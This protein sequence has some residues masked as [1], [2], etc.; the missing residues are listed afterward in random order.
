MRTLPE[1]FLLFGLYGL[2]Y[3]MVEGTQ[4]AFAS[5]LLGEKFRAT[6]L[7]TFHTVIALVTLPSSVIAGFLWQYLS[8]ETTFIYGSLMGFIAALLFIIASRRI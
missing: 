8:P 3:A 4:R 2:V 7:G 6:G 5:D 1:F